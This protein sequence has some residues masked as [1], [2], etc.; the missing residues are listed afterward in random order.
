MAANFPAPFSQA[1]ALG[2]IWSEGLF[3][4]VTKIHEMTGDIPA[5]LLWSEERGEHP[6]VKAT[7]AL[8]C[9]MH[10]S[11]LRQGALAAW[12]MGKVCRESCPGQPQHPV[13]LLAAQGSLFPSSTQSQQ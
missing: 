8:V 9:V 5:W 12:T 11:F 10:K 13:E 3:S 7:S 4:G 1:K 2:Q 6:G